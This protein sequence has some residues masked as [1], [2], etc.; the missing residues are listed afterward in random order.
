M[1]SRSMDTYR[2]QF[3]IPSEKGKQHIY[4]CGN[5]LGL[6]PKKVKDSIEREL[7]YWATQGVEG[8][9]SNAF[10]WVSYHKQFSDLLA[11]LV[12]AKSREV[13]AMNSLTVNL[14]LLM[15]SFYRPTNK[16]FKILCEKEVF[17]SDYFAF[18]S[19]AAFHGFSSSEAL[20]EVSIEE[21][22]HVLRE[23]LI[24]EKI[25]Q[26][27]QQ[28]ACVVLGAV[29]F[30]TGQFLDLEKIAKVCQKY[31]IPFG[32]DLAHA[33]GNVP[34]ELSNWGVDFAVWC[35]Y[36]YL[37]GGPGAVG[38]AFVH[39]KHHHQNL[40]RLQGWW[41][42]AE[43][44]RFLMKKEFISSGTVDAWQLSNAPVLSM[45]ALKPSLQLFKEVGIAK[46]SLEGRKMSG[47][48]IE[49][50]RAIP[51]IEVVTPSEDERRGC[52]VSLWVKKQSKELNLQ[53]RAHGIIADWR[54]YRDGG[55]IRVAPVPLYNTLDEIDQFCETLTQLQK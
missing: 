35:S 31:E 42:T 41:G 52:Q 30:V 2:D 46:L 45:A 7:S 51:T 9:F 29:N 40:P 43:E 49:K 17:P 55:I 22:E 15:A 10:P 11:P 8:H 50:L 36:K 47:Y 21:G 23:E 1:I 6:Q 4:F 37:N 18:E 27:H 26:Q 44:E 3:N 20:L 25:H 16:R 48:L 38:G 39:E 14:H 19:Q 33:I 12:G 53:L 24:I 32:V 13:V 28:L 34:L 54:R 5:S